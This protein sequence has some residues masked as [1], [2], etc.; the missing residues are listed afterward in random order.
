M[1]SLHHLV[2]AS[3]L[4]IATILLTVLSAQAQTP[5][6]P[7]SIPNTVING[8]LVNN[9]SREFFEAGRE[10]LEAEIRTLRQRELAQLE[11]LL[12]VRE[13]A[14]DLP[15]DALEEWVEP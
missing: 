7:R 15:E 12:T 10:Q 8:T 14:R 13:D 3:S 11:P 5:P 6:P 4:A 2:S 9:A 1:K